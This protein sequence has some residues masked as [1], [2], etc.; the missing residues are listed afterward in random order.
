[1]LGRCVGNGG[2]PAYRDDLTEWPADD[3]DARWRRLPEHNMVPGGVVLD[4]ANPCMANQEREYSAHGY[5]SLRP[6]GPHL[7]ETVHLHD[8]TPVREREVI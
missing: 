2:F 3:G 8:G 7:T 5:V 6:D 1:M 4:M